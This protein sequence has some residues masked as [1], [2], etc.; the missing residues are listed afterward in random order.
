MLNVPKPEPFESLK[1]IMHY[2]NNVNAIVSPHGSCRYANGIPLY[3][4]EVKSPFPGKTY[5]PPVFDILPKY[6][7]LSEMKVLNVDQLYFVCY[8]TESTTVQRVIYT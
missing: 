2:V 5:T 8:S 4:I 7:V 1:E 3:G 6:Y